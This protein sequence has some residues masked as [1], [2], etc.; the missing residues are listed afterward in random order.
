MARNMPGTDLNALEWLEGRI[1]GWNANFATIGLTSAQVIDL[2][3]KVTNT[4]GA[5]TSVESV[6][7]DSKAKTQ[8][9]HALAKDMRGG[10]GILIGAI[11]SFAAQSGDAQLVYDTAG[12]LPADARSPASPPE[13]PTDVNRTLL[14]DGSVK[15]TWRGRGPEGTT[16]FITRRLNGTGG[17]T[18][19]GQATSIDKSFVDNTF[20]PGTITASY[21]VQGV[22]S[23]IAGLQSVPIV[24]Q[25]GVTS[26]VV[27]EGSIAA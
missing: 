20:P 22:R 3:Q 4:R 10:A 18:F 1:V 7:T 11:K 23:G 15:L 21:M 8:N 12:V 6:R 16:Y 13:Q 5:F 26:D 2:S 25:F 17:Y 27:A 9:F 19:I 14:A 24:V